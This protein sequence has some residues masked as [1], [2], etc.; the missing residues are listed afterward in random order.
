MSTT[1]AK[2]MSFLKS[3]VPVVPLTVFGAI[4]KAGYAE[5]T[6]DDTQ[7]VA[8]WVFYPLLCALTCLMEGFHS[9]D[10]YTKVYAEHSEESSRVWYVTSKTVTAF[11][12]FVAVT[13]FSGS[14]FTCLFSYNTTVAAV[15]F[16]LTVAVVAAATVVEHHFWKKLVPQLS[17]PRWT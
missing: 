17:L 3:N 1:Y 11:L 4:V 14:P 15:V 5:C 6:A 10:E 13:Y 7:R 9:N 2:M 12:V 8:F 16:Y